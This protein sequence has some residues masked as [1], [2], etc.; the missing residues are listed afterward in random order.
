M[1]TLRLS[2][3]ALLLQMGLAQALNLGGTDVPKDHIV[4]YILIGHSNMAGI[5]YS[6][7]DNTPSPNVWNYQWFSNKQW[8]E[9]K[10]APGS[11]SNGL[12]PNGEGGPGMPFLKGLAAAH[13]GYYIGVISNASLSATVRGVDTGINTSGLPADSNRYFKGAHLYNQIM[14][15]AQSIE[16]DVTFGGIVCMLGTV[17]ATRTSTATC[18]NFAN[19]VDTMVTD[20]RADLGLPNLPYLMGEYEHGATGN[21]SLSLPW[22]HLVD[23]CIKALPSM[24]PHSATVNSV[25]IPMKDDHHYT[26]PAGETMFADRADSLVAANNFFTQ[27]TTAIAPSREEKTAAG[28]LSQLHL[29][30]QGEILSVLE[31][32]GNSRLFRVNGS[33]LPASAP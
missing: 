3:L 30:P 18:Q 16:A 33:R 6:N 8:V 12:S 25:G 28:A 26:W 24:L 21:F 7:T 1:K 15:V 22:P 32:D 17:D 5:T 31:P 9:A 14:G 29:Q 10:E 2:V 20:M 19:D 11:A 23:S 4:V 13:P 27:V